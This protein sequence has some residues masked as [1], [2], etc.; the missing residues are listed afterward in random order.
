MSYASSLYGKRFIEDLVIYIIMKLV[1]NF[2]N[3]KPYFIVNDHDPYL[4]PTSNC[5]VSTI[6]A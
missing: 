5:I 1:P 4:K 3:V 2:S 6:T